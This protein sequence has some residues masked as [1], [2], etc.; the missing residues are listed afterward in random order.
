MW[1]R[2]NH[3]ARDLRDLASTHSMIIHKLEVESRPSDPRHNRFRLTSHR[4]EGSEMDQ[5]SWSIIPF[6][7]A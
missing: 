6:A 5:H 7:Q 1:W 3:F 2:L 4:L